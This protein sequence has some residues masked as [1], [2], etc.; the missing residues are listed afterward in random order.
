M[1]VVEPKFFGRALK[2]MT[3]ENL[4]VCPNFCD[5]RA[6]RRL[7]KKFGISVGA[8]NVCEFENGSHTGDVSAQMLKY[9]GATYCIVGHSE[10]KLH[11]LETL[12][13]TN[14]KVRLLQQYGITPIVCVGEET[15]KS[16]TS[17]QTEYAK[18]YVLAE[19]DVILKGV[20]AQNVIVAY[21]P[22]W[23]IGTGKVATAQHIQSV[24]HHIKKC[25]GISK[26]LY[27]GSFSIDNYK[28]IVGIKSVDGALIGGES[29]HPNNIA[30]M[31]KATC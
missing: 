24:A 16:A 5:L 9:A 23:A 7:I 10:Q 6:Y 12:A 18:K 4:I 14:K 28:Q 20:D 22:I 17:N 29:L 8:Q 31:I 15:Q 21:E 11:H 25:V 1:N 3:A 13:K 30:E 19:L 2:G 27:G 26:V